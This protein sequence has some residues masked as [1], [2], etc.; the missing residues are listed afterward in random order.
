MPY[1][2]VSNVGVALRY[3]CLRSNIVRDGWR[4]LATAY[5]DSLQPVLVLATA[6]VVSFMHAG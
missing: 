1:D 6:T 4:S 5:S 2:D 3:V